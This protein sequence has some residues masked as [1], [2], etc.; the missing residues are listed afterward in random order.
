MDRDE[1]M[2]LLH[3]FVRQLISAGSPL[4]NSIDMLSLGT[5]EEEIAFALDAFSRAVESSKEI[6]AY[7]AAYSGEST[8]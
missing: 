5:P 4:L 7:L 8:E 6:A 1:R 3:K 2:E